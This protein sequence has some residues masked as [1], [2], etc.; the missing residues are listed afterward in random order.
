M[1]GGSY[2]HS[3]MMR[4]EQYSLKRR[5]QEIKRQQQQQHLRLNTTATPPSNGGLSFMGLTTNNNININTY[6]QATAPPQ[7]LDH[8]HED[9][10]AAAVVPAV[11][12]V[13][14]GRSICHRISLHKHGSYQSFAKALRRMFGEG[15]DHDVDDK[16]L[17]LSNAVPG[18]LIAYE[19][20]E[21]DLLLAGDL[22]WKDF[23]RV[24]RRIRIVPAKSNSRKPSREEV[25]V[26]TATTTTT[27]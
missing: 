11:T 15:G 8:R 3:Q 17:D 27:T 7:M 5:W 22:N 20:M 9:L 24:A 26:T 18:H 21:N 1:N 14:E 13:L 12:V 2:D 25:L 23:V 10:V 6:L 16:D 19:D 4:Q